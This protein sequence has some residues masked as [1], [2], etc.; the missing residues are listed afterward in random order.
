MTRR[1]RSDLPP[2]APTAFR[3]LNIIITTI[4]ITI[5]ARS[6][7]AGIT[8]I[9]IT[10]TAATIT[11]ITTTVSTWQF[12]AATHRNGA[13]ESGPGERPGPFSLAREFGLSGFRFRCAEDVAI[14]AVEYRVCR[15]GPLGFF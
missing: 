9:T 2:K 5:A 15:R 1:V 14:G 4:I 12:H 11:I 6:L 13:L 7:F 10:T 3:W 8:I